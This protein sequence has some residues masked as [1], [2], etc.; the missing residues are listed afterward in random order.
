M[1]ALPQLTAVALPT[2]ASTEQ[3]MS[4]LGQT[5]RHLG[6]EGQYSARGTVSR[7]SWLFPLN[8]SS[9]AIFTRLGLCVLEERRQNS[10]QTLFSF[11]MDLTPRIITRP[12]IVLH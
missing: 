1:H 2:A 11:D 8:S 4:G 5:K 12:Y 7:K 3:G 9:M 10:S 6:K